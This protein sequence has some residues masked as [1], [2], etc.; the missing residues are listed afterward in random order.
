MLLTKFQ[1]HK[2][3]GSEEEDFYLIHYIDYIGMAAILVT[4]S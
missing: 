4:W 2:P 1:G 3:F